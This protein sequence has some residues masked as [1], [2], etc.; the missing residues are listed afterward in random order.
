MDVWEMNK[1]KGHSKKQIMLPRHMAWCIH[2]DQRTASGTDFLISVL[3][4]T[5]AS[6]R[7]DT[8]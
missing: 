4:F 5:T 3:P 7:V 8:L 2:A 1:Q 6:T